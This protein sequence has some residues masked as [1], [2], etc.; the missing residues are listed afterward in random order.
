MTTTEFP[1]AWVLA[2]LVPC[3]C[4]LPPDL[5]EAGSVDESDTSSDEDTRETETAETETA[6][7]ETGESETGEPEPHD[8]E[9]VLQGT[10]IGGG[11]EPEAFALPHPDVCEVI[12][13][14]GWG[15]DVPLLESKW[16]TPADDLFGFGPT[17]G[18]LAIAPDN[19]PVMVLSAP[20]Q[21][22]MIQW[23]TP[24]GQHWITGSTA[25]I[26]GEVVDFAIDA[27][28]D[29]YY[30]LWHDGVVQRLLAANEA[31]EPIFDIELGN[32]S[33]WPTQLEVVEDGLIAIVW[34]D[35]DE[36]IALVRIDQTG[37]I[38]F[39][40]LDPY[41]GRIDVSPS[42]NVIAMGNP[43]GLSWFDA[44][45]NYLGGHELD[46]GDFLGPAG[47][48]AVD[49]THVVFAG[50][51]PDGDLNGL[52]LHRGFLG[53]F[54]EMGAGWSHTYDRA[55]TWC[56]ELD[57]HKTQEVLSGVEQLADGTLVVTGI[58][59]LGHPY[60]DDFQS[61]SQPWIAHV[62][63]DGEDVL[64]YDRGFWLGQP[65]DLVTRDNVAYVLL[66]VGYNSEDIGQ[67]YLRKYVF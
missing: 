60:E 28:E 44:Q 58:E 65:I 55:D 9:C 49:D 12:C 48:L 66:A 59:S 24:E 35:E 63:A 22:Y 39:A 64:A 42:G 40:H 14:E 17:H 5:L 2:L 56:V 46:F 34:V 45:G 6:E 31:G 62:S 41:G 13:A 33:P 25:D 51:V 23:L 53:E 18:V 3:A 32:P 50:S 19:K 47:F 57:A 16:T 61:V 27:D 20:E 7:T 38:V 54:S 10:N 8:L 21:P 37:D 1:R 30:F 26:T 29:V 52:T 36:P 4:Q 11:P 15:H 67:P 43:L